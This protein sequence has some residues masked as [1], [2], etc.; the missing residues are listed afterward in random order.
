VIANNKFSENFTTAFRA[1][2]EMVLAV[3]TQMTDGEFQIYSQF[4]F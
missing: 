1:V 4:S 2:W 3:L